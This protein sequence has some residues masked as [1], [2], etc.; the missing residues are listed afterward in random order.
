MMSM[1]SGFRS[2]VGAE[3]RKSKPGGSFITWLLV[4]VVIILLVMWMTR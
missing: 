1:R 4:A 2:L 3:R